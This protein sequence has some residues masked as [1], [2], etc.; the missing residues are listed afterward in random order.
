MNTN[1]LFMAIALDKEQKTD[2]VFK[3]YE[4]ICD[5]KVLTV[6][7]TKE[8]MCKLLNKDIDKD[9][10]YLT[11]VEDKEGNLVDNLRLTFYVQAYQYENGI[12][13]P[14]GIQTITFFI[15]NAFKTNKDKTKVQVI[16]KYGRTAWVTNEECNNH[17]IPMY[18]NGPARLDVDYRP[19]Y[20]GEGELTSFIKSFVNISN[21]DIYNK[22]NGT[23]M[24]HPDPSA[25]ECRL[26]TIKKFFN[27]DINEIKDVVRAYPNNKVKTL[28]Y[29]NTTD[30][31]QF[32]QI[33]T[34]AFAA[35]RIKEEQGI[36]NFFAKKVNEVQGSGAMSGIAFKIASIQKYKV[37]PTFTEV[38]E[39]T[40]NDDELPW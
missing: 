38:T 5:V 39:T 32:Q 10:I 18:S 27:G 25:C 9:P 7:P 30:K 3:M 28:W 14:E 40:T 36:L 17:I 31:G 19:I 8:E 35:P 4:G 23:W 37:A 16:D 12:T 33:F 15:K 1:K 20:Q 26:D 34:R 11:K 24:N 13:V 21:I 2:N 29:I 6:N 22:T